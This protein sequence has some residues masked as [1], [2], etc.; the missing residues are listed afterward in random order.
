MERIAIRF[1]GMPNSGK[2]VTMNQI[3]KDLNNVQVIDEDDIS[4]LESANNFLLQ[5]LSKHNNK[6]IILF[7]AIYDIKNT[8]QTNELYSDNESIIINCIVPNHTEKID[9]KTLSNKNKMLVQ[10]FNAEY[11]ENGFI[12]IPIIDF[13]KEDKY[14]SH[15]DIFYSDNNFYHLFKNTKYLEKAINRLLETDTKS[16]VILD[17][18]KMILSVVQQL[19]GHGISTG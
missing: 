7:D 12:I 13:S 5:Q 11:D 17:F 14:M 16:D 19:E 3:A 4:D 15:F 10:S 1:F 9:P 6:K 8:E 18:Q 2:S